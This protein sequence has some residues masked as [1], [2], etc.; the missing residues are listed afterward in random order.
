MVGLESVY[1]QFVL[2]LKDPE[3]RRK[4]A[5]LHS[6]LVCYS[7]TFWDEFPL[8]NKCSTKDCS[9]FHH[10]LFCFLT[11]GQCF[12]VIEKFKSHL[13]IVQKLIQRPTQSF[14]VTSKYVHTHIHTHSHTYIHNFCVT[15]CSM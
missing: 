5:V 12:F 15:T 14:C 6:N 11:F 8:M 10:N 2:A 3:G 13:S 4:T 9:H 1:I 7:S